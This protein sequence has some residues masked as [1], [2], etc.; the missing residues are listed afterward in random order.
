MATYLRGQDGKPIISIRTAFTNV[1]YRAN[2]SP[3]DPHPEAPFASRLGK[4]GV[5][6]VTL[7]KLERWKE[8]KM[9]LR[10][11]NLSLEHLADGENRGHSITVL[12]AAKVVSS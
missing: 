6:N 7:Q 9:I 10:F 2:L 11:G 5:N 8:S 4:A 12:A 1:C 3:S